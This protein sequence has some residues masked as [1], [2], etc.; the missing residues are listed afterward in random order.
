[1]ARFA[2]PDRLPPGE[3]FILEMADETTNILHGRLPALVERYHGKAE[4]FT[5]GID[6]EARV[7]HSLLNLV[8]AAIA[9]SM[10]A[11][12]NAAWKIRLD[13]D[14]WNI[15]AEI[16]DH[17]KR[18]QEKLRILRDLALKSFEVYEFRKRIQ[19]YEA[20]ASE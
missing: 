18:R 16:D 11:V 15:L 8:P 3:A 20:M 7:Q 6:E 13:L 10:T 9:K 14:S 12:V 2:H 5:T 19:Q 4:C 17:S 1:V